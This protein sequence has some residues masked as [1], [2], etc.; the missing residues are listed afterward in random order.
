M[1]KRAKKR[2]G[3]SS[4]AAAPAVGAATHNGG[5]PS[6]DAAA[7]T[8]P[9]SEICRISEPLA[10]RHPPPNPNHEKL[11]CGSEDN[12]RTLERARFDCVAKITNETLEWTLFGDLVR[13]FC[14]EGPVR[15]SAGRAGIFADSVVF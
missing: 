8:H 3:R 4:G 1:R 11:D 2:P 6:S 13:G 7:Y 14:G 5:G 12:K 10:R 9:K 15:G